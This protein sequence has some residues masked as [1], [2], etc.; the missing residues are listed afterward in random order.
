[1]K[2]FSILCAAVLMAASAFAEKG[3]LKL[4]SPMEFQVM[5]VSPNGKWACGVIGDGQVNIAQAMLWNMETGETMVLSGTSESYAFDVTDDGMV[6]GSYTDYEITGNGAG[7]LVAGWYKDGEWHRFDNTTIEG[8]QEIGS[9]VYA[10]SADGRIAVGYVQDGPKDSDLAP[11]KWVDGKL[12]RIY[13]HYVAGVAYAVSDD[14]KYATGWGYQTY[15]D[16]DSGYNR[17]IALWTDETVEMI[18]DAPTFAE[19]GRKISPDNT[20][21]LCDAFG[22][23][24]VYDIVT[25]EKNYLPK[26]AGE[27]TWSQNMFYVN[28][29]GLV[30]G[31]EDMRDES[32]GRSETYGYVYDG[33]KAWKMHEWLKETYNVDLPTSEFIIQSGVDMSADGKVIVMYGYPFEDGMM[34]GAWA[35]MAILLD[36]EVDHCEPVALK[37][38]KVTALNSVRL[39]WKEPLSN[40]SEVLG[41]NVYR[42]GVKIVA[43]TAELAYVDNLDA[44]G[45]YTYTVTAI[46][47]GEGDELIE[48]IH[49]VAAVAEVYPEPLHMAQNIEYH[50]VNYNDLKLRWAEPESNLPS[51]T[52][53]DKNGTFTGFGGGLYSFT[54]AICLPHDVVSNFAGLYS[55]ARVSFMPLHTDAGY[56][57]KIYVDGSEVVNQPVNSDNL[58]YGVMNTVDLNTPVSIRANQNVLVAIDIDASKF[59]AGSDRVIGASYGNCVSGYSDL[60]HNSSEPEFY[61]LNQSSI[62]AGFGE[63][64]MCWAISAVFATLDENGKANVGA[65]IVAGYDVYRD[66]NKLAS[67]TETNYFDTNVAEGLHTYGI[68]VKYASGE[69]AEAATIDID[70][71]A[72]TEALPAIETVKIKA[73]PSLI[74]ASW[75]APLNNDVTFITY[76]KKPS[77][78]KGISLAGATDLIEYTCAADFPYNYVEWYD[79]YNIEAIRFYPTAEATFAVALEVNGIDHEFIVLNGLGEEGGYTLNA[80]NTVKLETPIKIAPGATYRVKVYCTDVDPSTNPMCLDS[81][82]GLVGVSDLYSWDYSSYSSANVDATLPG[83]WMLGMVV[84]N[85]NTDAL[86]VDGYNVML[87]GK[88]A[89][90]QLVKTTSFSQE[91]LDWKEGTTHRVKVNTVYAVN[92]GTL[93]VDGV[94]Q[95]F[96]VSPTAVEGIEVDRVKVYPNPATSFIAV[97]GDAEKLVLID[98][99]GRTVAETTADVLDVTSLPVGNYLLNV[100]NNGDVETVKVVIVR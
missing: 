86:P 96:T 28:N 68:V 13:E 34:V 55:L 89:N 14:G 61:S 54:V 11:A 66:N 50:A 23:R 56:S 83:N 81:G 22:T 43:E 39:T 41:Y 78:G 74:E 75:N 38:E 87:D 37:A 1:M 26:L 25:K 29:D 42:D 40:A 59:T 67:V 95:I 24:Y 15:N 51:T 10:V 31:G 72:K 98:M 45:T 27:S 100:H 63:M 47:G 49:S 92:G 3:A 44:E 16:G 64:P 18:S 58:Q 20:K 4:L 70:F 94:Q 57:I 71:T 7:T 17:S 30:L 69:D 5:A 19:A 97:E 82:I 84:A 77:S 35:S 65:D 79:G 48:S 46:Y 80:W 62:D 93:E 52:Y 6:V 9:E 12:E 88:Q 73:E 8:V 91:G 32:T 21:L 2:K 33:D 76:S 85:D 53:Y 36:R 90:T 99:A 60:L